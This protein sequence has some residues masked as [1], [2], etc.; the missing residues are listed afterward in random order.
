MGFTFKDDRDIYFFN[1]EDGIYVRCSHYLATIDEFILTL[2]SR[3]AKPISFDIC[4]LV[5]NTFKRQ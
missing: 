4:D 2:K 5:K 3:N 1:L